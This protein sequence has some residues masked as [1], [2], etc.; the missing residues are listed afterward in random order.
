MGKRSES[1]N[2]DIAVLPS[3]TSYYSF[4][5]GGRKVSHEMRETEFD[6]AANKRLS[7]YELASEKHR[8]PFRHTPSG[9]FIPCRH[10][11]TIQSRNFNS[12]HIMKSEKNFWSEYGA[13]Q[14]NFRGRL[15]KLEIRIKPR[16]ITTGCP[17]PQFDR[18][19]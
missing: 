6:A 10:T 5:K 3:G 8:F 16:D 17:E 1:P 19:I 14:P 7:A 9:V 12:E 2:S 15:H 13:R 18:H 11:I 4:A